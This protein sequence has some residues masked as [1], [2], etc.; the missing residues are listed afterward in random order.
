MG[1]RD[2][3]YK[4]AFKGTALFGG[5]Q[6]FQIFISLVRGKIVALFLGPEGMGIS[7]LYTSSLAML[8]TIAGLGC[9]L[10]AVRFI[11]SLERGSEE[12][13]KQINI[14]KKIFFGVALFGLAL[15][16]LFAIPLS[17][18]T[19]QNKRHVL[20]YLL[21]SLYVFFSLYNQ[22]QGSILQAM[23]ELKAIAIGNV[24]PAFVA[25]VVSVPLYYFFKLNAIVP[26]L[27]ILPLACSI[28]MQ[29][30]IESRLRQSELSKA[31]ASKE[32]IWSTFREFVGLGLVTVLATLL[33]N[34]TVYLMNAFI[35]RTGSFSDIGLFNAGISITN[36]YIGLVFSAMAVDYFPRLVSVCNDRERMNETVNNQGEVILLLGLPLLSV[37]M[38]TA[39][40]CI[41]ILLSD[42]FLIINS[43]IRIVAYGMI[44]KIASFCMG[45]ISFAKGDK[46]TYLFLE[47][48][49]SN[50]LTLSF[51]C[52]G[53]HFMGLKGL[54]ISFCANY[55]VY[56]FVISFYTKFK[57][58]FSMARSFFMLI[59]GAAF[60]VS[61]L[62]LLTDVFVQN[63]LT[64]GASALLTAAICAYSFIQLNAKIQLI[65]SLKRKAR[66][67][68]GV[69]SDS[70][71][72]E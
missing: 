26:V 53:Y 62:L 60:A 55:I 8:I 49:F 61:V 38:L 71:A 47:G 16:L 11:S 31:K 41:K 34:L 3:E 70:G 29:V 14:T 67:F 33:G 15:T 39:P 57:Y 48:G 42:E 58:G 5:V 12:Y 64:I 37:M 51:N 65:D 7:G 43:F 72:T 1:Q 44:F 66:K 30:V 4:K 23:Q 10:S 59:A 69:K 20:P 40:I 22:G 6:I 54:A 2:I 50:I 46:K 56:L 24:L 21:L 63:P 28:Y 13:Y 35:S 45:Y 32:E 17:V 68:L 36:Q 19:F 18:F 25:L 27:V 52:L 9:S